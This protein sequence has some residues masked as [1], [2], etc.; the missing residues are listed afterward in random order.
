MKTSCRME[1]FL[2]LGS[3]VFAGNIWAQGSQTPTKAEKRGQPAPKPKICSFSGRGPITITANFGGGSLTSETEISLAASK[4][5]KDAKIVLAKRASSW[6]T[7]SR[8]TRYSAS[9][10][11]LMP[12]CC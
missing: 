9:A 10:A 2:L 5:N 3:A 6:R 8:S 4:S 11:L 12:V 1:L 7:R